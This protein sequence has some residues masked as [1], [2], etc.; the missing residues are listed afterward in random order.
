MKTIYSLLYRLRFN[1]LQSLATKFYLKLALLV[2]VEIA[3]P[4]I[5]RRK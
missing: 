3:R 4:A 5:D 2:Q 1:L